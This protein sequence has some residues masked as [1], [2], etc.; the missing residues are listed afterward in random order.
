M[1][2]NSDSKLFYP[3]T[4]DGRNRDVALSGEGFFEVR[5]DSL[6][7]MIVSTTR[8][9]KLE[10]LGTT[11]N[12]KSYDNDDIAEATLYSGNVNLI[13]MDGNGDVK[14]RQILSPNQTVTID[15]NMNSS[16]VKHGDQSILS[17]WKEGRIIFD[18]TPMSEVVK[19]LNRWHGVEFEIRDPEIL[20]DKMT[21][22]FNSESVVQTMDLFKLTSDIDYEI[23]D[24]TVIVKKR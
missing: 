10:V 2:L 11:F 20:D 13:M 19:I 21:A 4:F 18:N 22:R 3:E 5:R 16:L 12:L 6:R 1:W 23:K 14:M 17:A 15:R 9:F 24:K 7:P 8:G